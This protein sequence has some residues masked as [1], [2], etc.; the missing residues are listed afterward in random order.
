[1]A[2]DHP[3]LAPEEALHEL[4]ATFNNSQDLQQIS[5]PHVD[6]QF[7]NQNQNQIMLQ[8]GAGPAAPPG[9]LAAPQH[10]T[11]MQTTTTPIMNPPFVSPAMM[12]LGMSA[13]NSPRLR[14]HPSATATHASSPGAVPMMHQ[15]SQQIGHP[16]NLHA[17]GMSRSTSVGPGIIALGSP[18]VGGPMGAPGGNANIV[19]AGNKRRRASAVAIPEDSVT[20]T[21]DVGST[22][23]K[24]S[25]RGA[26]GKKKS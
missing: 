4:V 3:E 18:R 9:N 24:A 11:P 20:G 1:Y 23:I 5:Q 25:P 19:L 12:N 2:H 21:P 17:T 14:G 6:Q 22:R 10:M 13:Q 16:P 15:R 8:S 7:H 26:A